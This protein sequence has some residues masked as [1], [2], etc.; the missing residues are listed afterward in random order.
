MKMER[1]ALAQ[2]LEV[3]A[4]VQPS[5]AEVGNLLTHVDDS[6]DLLCHILLNTDFLVRYPDVAA[7]LQG[8]SGPVSRS[9][10]ASPD[11]APLRERM[12]RSLLQELYEKQKS[13]AS[14]AEELNQLETEILDLKNKITAVAKNGTL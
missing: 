8:L 9:L 4:D 2:A 13:W 7:I 5:D 3:F 10:L 11:V 6:K 1:D 12:K 14:K